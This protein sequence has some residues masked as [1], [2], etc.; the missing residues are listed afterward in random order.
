[1]RSLRQ[2]MDSPMESQRIVKRFYQLAAMPTLQQ[3]NDEKANIRRKWR[4][5]SMD[6]RAHALA[7]ALGM[8][9]RF[10]DIDRDSG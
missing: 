7:A 4:V 2:K 5:G 8:E 1:M 6:D 10:E 3:V 9:L